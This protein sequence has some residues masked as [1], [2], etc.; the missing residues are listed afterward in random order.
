MHKLNHNSPLA[1][2]RFPPKRRFIQGKAAI[3]EKLL[4]GYQFFKLR[5]VANI[6]CYFHKISS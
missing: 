3:K 6:Q 5:V 2:I 1:V 4:Y